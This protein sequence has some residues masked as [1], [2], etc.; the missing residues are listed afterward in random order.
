[1]TTNLTAEVSDAPLSEAE[2]LGNILTWSEGR[3]N[4]QRDALRRLISSGAVLTEEDINDLFKISMD[5]KSPFDPLAKEHI[6]SGTIGGSPVS[7]NVVA[8]PTGINALADDQ[9]VEF[10][11][12]GLTVVYGDNASGKSGYVRIL[13]HA[14]RS[15]D[16]KFTIL[17]DINGPEASRQ[18]AR[19][20]FQ[21]GST[22]EDFDWTPDGA[23]H[24]RLPS[25]SIFD[26]RSATTHLGGQHHV[27]Y[28]P[29]PME[30][31]R[32]LGVA[33]EGLKARFDDQLNTLNEQTPNV[34]KNHGLNPNT[35]AGAFM[36][37]LSAKTELD[38]IEPITSLSEED[39]K[40]HD[41]LQADLAGD[42]SKLIATL[43]SQRSRL[44]SYIDALILLVETSNEQAFLSFKELQA[45]YNRRKALA[46]AA[47]ED[48]FAASPLPDIGGGLWKDLWDAA[49]A[50]SDNQA[51]PSGAFPEIVI[52]EDLCVLCQQ[53]VGSEA[54]IRWGKFE[55]F[56][57]GTTKADE[58][59]ARKALSEAYARITASRITCQQALAVRKLVRDEL[60][61]PS[62]AIELHKFWVISSFR[63]RALVRGT[64]ATI[65]A[66]V[67]AKNIADQLIE[68]INNRIAGIS[69]D[70]DSDARKALVAE[71]GELRDRFKLKAIQKDLE[72]H[73]H[74]LK[75]IAIMKIASST[76]AKAAVTNKNKELSDMLVTNSLRC[77]FAREVSKL[78]IMSAPVE[79]VK[80]RDRNAQSFF[81]VVLADRPKQP[82]YDVLSEGEHRCIAL[83][84]F[85]A[86]LVT[87]RE[88]SGIVFDDPMSSLDHLYRENVAA[89][90]VEESE[91]RQVVIFTHD[92]TFLFGIA[93]QTELQKRE[94]KYQ[95]IRR[96]PG[97]SP[98]FVEDGL[99]FKAMQ[100]RPMENSIRSLL[101]G[102]K[103]SFNE[104]P[105]STRSALAT[106][107][108]AQIRTA[109]EQGI[110]DFLHPVLARFDDKVKPGSLFKLL[111][112]DSEDVKAVEA[113]RSRLSGTGDVHSSSETLN[114]AELT[115][116][117]LVRELDQLQS[118]LQITKEKQ[119][120][121]QSPK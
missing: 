96:I 105:E 1:M 116:E 115:H 89:R 100:A 87:S 19:I 8:K 69:A 83:A 95:T 120:K 3:P 64:A 85:L 101:K 109:W 119:S 52:D 23:A 97:R 32:E 9:G 17:P 21:Y 92:L 13:K 86:E 34:I 41:E 53:P 70:A 57:K 24:S 98:G 88:Y 4:W 28:T 33:C 108:I 102:C 58:E 55:E 47:S 48:L 38:E 68:K 56:I 54:A 77:R 14:C 43:S 117:D 45:T 39:Q 76:T 60:G 71:L 35:T 16:E 107:V 31:L 7:L 121:A 74:R 118:W 5:I 36:S 20:T 99:P 80:T 90:L 59:S 44:R 6:Q 49:R 91:H 103:G 61:D 113:A 66:P 29:F 40:R 75:Q 22:S 46:Q 30:V 50:Y 114:P 78:K 51:K 11:P 62:L 79:L 42:P 65:E 94:V 27:A 110:A 73:I 26:S 104:M 10:S 67:V 72:T 37:T 111:P 82:I 84:A 15:R 2:A 93:R 81:N 25:V 106:G 18:S 63:L 12:T 112:L